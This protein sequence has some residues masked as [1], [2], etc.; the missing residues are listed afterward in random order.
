MKIK[1]IIILTSLTLALI[2]TLASYFITT[3]EKQGCHTF[4]SNGWP[5]KYYYQHDFVNLAN[6]VLVDSI[7]ISPIPLFIM[8][9]LIYFTAVFILIVIIA[10]NKI[11]QIKHF[12][13]RT[14]IIILAAI[15]IDAV[16]VI[17]LL[18]NHQIL[19]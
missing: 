17:Y 13:I 14:I 18:F 8:D 9:W 3:I 7:R 10:R 16:I 2:L 6:C 4:I 11:N 1:T 5:I 15:L 12:I 19:Y